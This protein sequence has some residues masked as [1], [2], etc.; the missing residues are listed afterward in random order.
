MSNTEAGQILDSANV[1]P[2]TPSM[3]VANKDVQPT[4]ANAKAHEEPISS[5]LQVLMERER[6]ALNR[7][8]YAKTQEESLKEK[9]LKVQQ[10]ESVKTDPKKALEFLGLSYD[11][12]TQSILKDG[13]V[14]P[15]VEIKRLRDELDEHK[16]QLKQKWDHE[17]EEQKKQVVQAESKAVSEFKTEISTYLK[18]NAA[19]YELIDFEGAHDLVFDV[20]DEHYNRTIDAESGVGKILPIKDA[21]DKVEEHLEK[22]YLAAKEKNKVKAF[23]SNMPK[24]IAEQLKSQEEKPKAYGQP[25][26]LTNS[27]SPKVLEKPQR[28]PEDQRIRQIVQ[29]HMAK[30]R[31]QYA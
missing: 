21:S 16:A 28:Q 3:G 11:E 26:T 8:R 31:S 14:P 15:S 18:D 24:G 13:E 6:Q 29:E 12:L 4:P 30:M 23:W 9:L 2:S 1:Q 22:K 17:A 10:F 27:M 25:R 5:K 19:R 7:E 20:I